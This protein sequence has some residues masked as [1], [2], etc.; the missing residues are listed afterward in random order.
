MESIHTVQELERKIQELEVSVSMLVDNGRAFA[1]AERDYKVALST[2]A[3]RLRSEGMAVTLIDKVIYGSV[4]VAEKRFQRD[5]A[6]ALYEANK[7]AINSLK[8]QIRILDGQIKQ[9]W[10]TA[11]F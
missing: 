4:A 6:E 7:E 1:S 9:D 10:G 3:L 2:E 11:K 5:V 8:L